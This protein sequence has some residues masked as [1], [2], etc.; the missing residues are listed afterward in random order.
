MIIS[1]LSLPHIGQGSSGGSVPGIPDNSGMVIP[2]KPS[3]LGQAL[4]LSDPH[5]FDPHRVFFSV[6]DHVE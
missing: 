4:K 1:S 6:A 2:S 5:C 3:E